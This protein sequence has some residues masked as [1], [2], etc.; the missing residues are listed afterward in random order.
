MKSFARVQAVYSYLFCCQVWATGEQSAL[1]APLYPVVPQPQQDQILSEKG[2][3][4]LN[5]E[6]SG[7][8]RTTFVVVLYA[9]CYLP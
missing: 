5:Y 4:N 1:T 7:R 2:T 8:Y 3:R 6:S 9:P